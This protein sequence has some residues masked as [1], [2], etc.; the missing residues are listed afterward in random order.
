MN[1]QVETS[2]WCIASVFL[3]IAIVTFLLIHPLNNAS[4]GGGPFSYLF[5]LLL[6]G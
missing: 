2:P 6:N 5:A 4:S 1:T 3:A